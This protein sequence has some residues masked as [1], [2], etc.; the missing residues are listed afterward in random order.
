M[1]PYPSGNSNVEKTI[2]KRL[3]RARVTIECAFAILSNKWR[4]SMK[5]IEIYTK[6]TTLIIK[7][8]S[9][10]HNIVSEVNGYDDQDFTGRATNLENR[11]FTARSRC[12]NRAWSRASSIRDQYKDYFVLIRSN[13][14]FEFLGNIDNNTDT[15]IPIY[16]W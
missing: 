5:S 16:L 6:R 7:V 14:F 3:S 15:G 13:L 1:H 2:F 8:A 10:L 12:N 4:V 11:I 9:L